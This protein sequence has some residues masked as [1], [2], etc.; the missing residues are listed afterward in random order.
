M[1]WKKKY[2]SMSKEITSF[3]LT[4]C[5]GGPNIFTAR[6]RNGNRMKKILNSIFFRNECVTTLSN[7][8]KSLKYT[9]GNHLKLQHLA[10]PLDKLP[11]RQ[12]ICLGD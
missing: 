6:R 4:F 7:R 12:S 3:L 8:Y 2:P 9:R 11:H 5:R 1:N 10:R